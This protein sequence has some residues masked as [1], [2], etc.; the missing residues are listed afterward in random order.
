MPMVLSIPA[1][2]DASSAITHRAAALQSIIGSPNE[3]VAT[4]A[5]IPRQPGRVNHV[6]PPPRDGGRP[7]E[8]RAARYMKHDKNSTM[9]ERVCSM[10]ASSCCVMLLVARHT[11][12]LLSSDYLLF[13]TPP[14]LDLSRTVSFICCHR[15]LASSTAWKESV[16]SGLEKLTIVC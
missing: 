15:Y 5:S 9:I 6:R 2:C 3:V 13:A 7:G 4:P 10:S 1:P 16:V 14:P 12:I 11:C 8:D